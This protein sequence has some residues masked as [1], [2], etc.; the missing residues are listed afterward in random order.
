MSLKAICRK[1]PLG[2]AAT[3]R[4]VAPRREKRYGVHS[5][6]AVGGHGH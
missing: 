6:Q 2:L 1:S 4:H 5:P 3:E